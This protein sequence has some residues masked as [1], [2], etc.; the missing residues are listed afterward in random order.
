MRGHVT[1][2]DR[3]GEHAQVLLGARAAH[4]D[5]QHAVLG[6]G[7]REL[8]VVV[9]ELVQAVDDVHAAAHGVEHDAALGAE[10][11]GR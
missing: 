8:Q 5:D 10:R 1:V 3:A 7:R 6:R 2:V 4:V 11:A 9:Q